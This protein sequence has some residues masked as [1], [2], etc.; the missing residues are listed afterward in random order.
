MGRQS[1]TRVEPNERSA[2]DPPNAPG[3]DGRAWRG[4]VGVD[5]TKASF[6][7]LAYA[8]GWAHR[9]GSQLVVVYAV[10]ERWQQSIDAYGS[11]AAQES[12]EEIAATLKQEVARWLC[13]ESV[14]WTFLVRGGE[15][16]HVLE[17]VAT[18]NDADAIIVGQSRRRRFHRCT[19]SRLARLR[20]RIVIAVP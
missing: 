20:Q 9:T 8:C 15:S 1:M 10:D 4:V 6:R 7:A 11:A 16:S 3:P 5:G 14:E 2:P 12:S 18:E 13:R 19:S 17:R